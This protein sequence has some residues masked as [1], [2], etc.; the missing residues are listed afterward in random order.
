MKQILKSALARA[1]RSLD[2]RIPGRIGAPAVAL[3]DGL[4]LWPAGHRDGECTAQ[5]HAQAPF[6]LMVAAAS[7]MAATIDTYPVQRQM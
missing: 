4:G 1:G 3:D 6:P 2:L 7:R 5:I